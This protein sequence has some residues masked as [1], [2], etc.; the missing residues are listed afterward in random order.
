MKCENWQGNNADKPINKIIL[1][2]LIIHD[3]IESYDSDNDVNYTFYV[4]TNSTYTTRIAVLCV[5]YARETAIG[6][7]S[8]NSN[9]IKN[10]SS[11]V[12]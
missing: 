8:Q 10:N 2:V 4:D 5:L 12:L 3:D 7:I 1:M 11:E 6:E 9:S